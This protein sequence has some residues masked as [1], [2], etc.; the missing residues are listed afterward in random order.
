MSTAD[1]VLGALNHLLKRRPD[2]EQ[3]V[4]VLLDDLADII[5]QL[6]AVRESI[7]REL[8]ALNRTLAATRAYAP[9]Q[10]GRR[11]KGTHT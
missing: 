7:G 5:R 9:P 10:A 3:Q 4:L 11:K 2:G 1:P 6:A 8:S